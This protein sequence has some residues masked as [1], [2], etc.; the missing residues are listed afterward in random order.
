M[1]KHCVQKTMGFKSEGKHSPEYCTPGIFARNSRRNDTTQKLN[2]TDFSSE[3]HEK[4]HPLQRYFRCCDTVRL[5]SAIF[6]ESTRN[7][8]RSR[9]SSHGIE[10][11]DMF[12]KSVTFLQ[13]C[14]RLFALDVMM[15]CFGILR[16][17]PT[18]Q[19]R[20][21]IETSLNDLRVK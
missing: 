16:T 10:L 7:I 17:L 14:A 19:T 9:T 8:A 13:Y 3:F 11:F 15:K 5:V 6:C 1:M 4:V 2:P 12:T 21:C 18:D 20:R